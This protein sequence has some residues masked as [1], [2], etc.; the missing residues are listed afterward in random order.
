MQ[1]S[2]KGN[3]P[4]DI[5][6]ACSLEVVKSVMANPIK[7]YLKKGKSAET[8]T[9]DAPALYP[10]NLFQGQLK[11]EPVLDHDKFKESEDKAT[12]INV[13]GEKPWIKQSEWQA[14]VEPAGQAVPGPV[15]KCGGVHEL[16]Q[17]EAGD[18]EQEE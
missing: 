10:C 9:K 14:A 8:F 11:W 5:G 13:G 7:H 1:L 3:H 12:A 18:A 6:F 2:F 16:D 17:E 4:G 15:G